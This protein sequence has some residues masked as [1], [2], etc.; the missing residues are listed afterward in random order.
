ML[1]RSA[2]FADL[3]AVIALERAAPN[4]AHWSQQQYEIALGSP[5]RVFSLAEEDSRISGLIVARVIAREWEIENIVVAGAK[6]R[7]GI[8]TALLAET[9]RYA[10]EQKAESIFLE[11]RESNVAARSL[12]QKNGFVLTGRRP[13]YYQ[14]PKEDALLYRRAVP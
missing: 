6:H 14:S 3:S 12:Y 1:I 2:I 9:V 10:R 5:E 7:R 13:H 11:V 4:A 8:G